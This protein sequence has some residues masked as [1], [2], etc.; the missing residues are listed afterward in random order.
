MRCNDCG[1][2]CLIYG[3]K[4]CVVCG[5][6]NISPIPGSSLDW[7]KVSTTTDID[8][9]YKRVWDANARGFLWLKGSDKNA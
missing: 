3:D 2:D 6:T 5:S 4:L 7:K 1:Y 8:E 9:E